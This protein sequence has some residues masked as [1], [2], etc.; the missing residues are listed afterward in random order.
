MVANYKVAYSSSSDITNIANIASLLATT[1]S[2]NTVNLGKAIVFNHLGARINNQA[3]LNTNSC[4]SIQPT[5]TTTGCTLTTG[6][7]TSVNQAWSKDATT[8]GFACNANYSGTDCQTYTAPLPAWT[9]LDTNCTKPDISISV[10]GGQTRTWAGCNSTLGSMNAANVNLYTGLCWNYIGTDAGTGACQSMTSKENWTGI[11]PTVAYA[12][13]Q[14]DN[15]Y[16]KLYRFDTNIKTNC[17]TK[18]VGGQTVYGSGT[19]CACPS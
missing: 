13:V 8:C 7:P 16:G 1:G 5:C 19:D 2:V 3:I 4:N 10:A 17:S 15:I 11:T 14:T 9:T 12:P 6:T 18:T